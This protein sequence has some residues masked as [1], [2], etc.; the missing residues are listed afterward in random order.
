[1]TY[2]PGQLA[3]ENNVSRNSYPSWSLRMALRVLISILT[4]Q[5]A[6]GFI[7]IWGAVVPNVRL[8]DHW[9]PLLTSAVFSAGPLGYG[10]GMVISGRLAESYPPRRLC[11]IAVGLMGSGFTVAFLIP[12]GLTF[13]LFYSAIALGLGG[14]VAL[15]GALAAGTFVFPTRVGT[16]GGALTAS[17][18]LAAVIEVPLVSNLAAVIG[19]LNSLRL[20]GCSVFLLAA[21]ALLLMPAIPRPRYA[22]AGLSTIS[23]IQLIRR[24]PIYTGFLLE[25]TASPLGSYA[26]VAVAAYARGLHLT[27]WI[28]TLAVTAVAAGNAIGRIAGGVASDRFGVNRVFLVILGADLLAALLFQRAGNGAIILCAALT[29]GLSFG[30]PAGVLSRLASTSAPEAPNTA[31]GLLFAGF[32]TGALY[33]PLLGAA[34]SGMAAPWLVLGAVAGVGCLVLAVRSVLGRKICDA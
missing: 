2:E 6:F 17:Y 33:G 22:R 7:Y 18:A 10:T 32:A 19:W 31:F 27:L 3:E 8:H 26:F 15:A 9:A 11:W 25:A 14:A 23:F 30:G 29:A 24:A 28:A 21:G 13:I 12:T 16:I 4:L 20:V 34:V 1:M 5:F